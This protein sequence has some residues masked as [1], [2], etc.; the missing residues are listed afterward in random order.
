[1]ESLVAARPAPEFTAAPAPVFALLDDA[2]RDFGPRPVLDFLGRRLTYA[3]LGRQVNAAAAGLQRLGV[4]RGVNVGLCLPNCPYSVIMYFAILKA[5]GT[6]VN[7]NP[8]YTAR[9]L[10]AQV[11]LT[12]LAIMVTLD[13]A[14]IQE[15]IGPL[16][17]QNLFRHVIV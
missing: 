8:L 15:K 6:V 1:M 4:A 10:E 12:H 7:F 2:V 5:G 14:L 11:K 13:L 3:E 17:A 9:E 16:A